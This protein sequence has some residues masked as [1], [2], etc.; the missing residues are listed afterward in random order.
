MLSAK[1]RLSSSKDFTAVTRRGHRTRCGGL[2][3]YVL[4]S[5]PDADASANSDVNPH[6][7]GHA[8]FGLVVGRTVG[9]S[10]IRHQV[11]RRLRHQ[12]RSRV[13]LVPV[14]ARV[15][16]RALP[17]AA[18]EDSAQLG[19]DLDRCFAKLARR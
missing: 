6:A 3:V 2:V 17:E 10:V 8:K 5:E 15:V 16:V 1:H 7:G 18:A 12:L 9:G 11:S 19:D 4:P 13:R 14:G